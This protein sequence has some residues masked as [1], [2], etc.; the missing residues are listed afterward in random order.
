MLELDS[1]DEPA[2]VYLDNQHI[3]IMDEI[4]QS[5]ASALQVVKDARQSVEHIQPKEEELAATLGVC[6]RASA[7]ED[8]GLGLF[9]VET[10]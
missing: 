4:K 10:V 9:N 6:L 3:A 1:T 2:W 7:R 5:Y 8:A